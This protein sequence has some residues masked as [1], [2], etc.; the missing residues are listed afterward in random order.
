MKKG[1]HFLTGEATKYVV[2]KNCLDC[3]II[4]DEMKFIAILIV[5]ISTS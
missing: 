1:I 3:N 2:F 4:P 5:R